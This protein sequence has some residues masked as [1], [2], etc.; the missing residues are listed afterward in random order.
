MSTERRWWV[1]ILITIYAVINTGFTANALVWAPTSA[2]DLSVQIQPDKTTISL[3]PGEQNVVS[4]QVINTG[5]FAWPADHLRLQTILP[6]NDGGAIPIPPPAPQPL[7]PS[8]NQTTTYPKITDT[9]LPNQSF[10]FYLPLTAPGNEGW[11]RLYL[12]PI[13]DN[14]VAGDVVTLNL[15][16]GNPGNRFAVLPEKQINVS[17]A[18]QTVTLWEGKFQ[19]I[20]YIASTGRTGWETPPGRYV[21][22]KK[23]TEVFSDDPINLWLPNWMELRDL[24]GVYEGYGIHGIPY[25]LVDPDNYT[26]GKR[27]GTS[28][29]YSDGK[30][31]EGYFALGKPISQGC[32]VLSLPNAET[33]F[34]WAEPEKTL[35]DIS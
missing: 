10:V 9:I 26:E 3:S 1:L 33:V 14:Q 4:F 19:I 12:Q 35:V 29:Y 28:Q 27:Y 34:R 24:N 20:K 18:D 6:V 30:L 32:I 5:I 23:L 16:V 25:Q 17:L 22:N 11:Y 31:Y 13:I 2:G 21:I 8:T 7:W 15:R